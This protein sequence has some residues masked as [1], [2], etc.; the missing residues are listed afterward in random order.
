MYKNQTNRMLA[1]DGVLQKGGTVDPVSGNDVP[2]GAMPEEV[3][4]DV[5]AKLSEGEFVVPADVVRYIGLAKLMEMRDEAK[6][7]L[8]KMTDI[9]QMGNSKKGAEGEAL[10]GEEVEDEKFASS[11][12]EIMSEEDGGKEEAA[13]ANGGYVP[14][15]SGYD[16]AESVALYS[17]APIKGFEMIPMSNDTGNTIY[18]PFINGKPQLQIPPGYVIKAKAAAEAA[19][20]VAPTAGG[21]GTTATQGGEGGQDFGG[22][23]GDTGGLPAASDRTDVRSAV[24]ALPD[25]LRYAPYVGTAF[26]AA[27]AKAEKEAAADKAYLSPFEAPMAAARSAFTQM[28]RD[29]AG[30]SEANTAMETAR[31]AFTASERSSLINS[32]IDT[33]IAN[34]TDP[35]AEI[36]AIV[37]D[38]FAAPVA[39]TTGVER[40]IL[41]AGTPLASLPP[42]T[43]KPTAM[44]DP[45]QIQQAKAAEEAAARESRA[46][47]ANE[48]AAQEARETANREAAAQSARETAARAARDTNIVGSVSDGGGY[49][50]IGGTTGG[51]DTMGFGGEYAKGGVVTKKDKGFVSSRQHSKNKR[52]GF[53]AKK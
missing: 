39:T 30:L 7:G 35:T 46:A 11:I 18:I 28:E 29:A 47:A 15:S 36:D 13:Y 44:L 3:R 21:T 6:R 17:R 14:R 31:S 34:K 1:Q 50:G 49:G 8:Q 4:D 40:G 26:A 41:G 42:E 20:P 10:H 9:G 38:M 5:D 24:L 27:R 33:S 51:S 22:P 16:P 32:I 12:D 53:V 48:A 52:T 19:A 43:T 25:A 45:A 37:A 23:T 2:P